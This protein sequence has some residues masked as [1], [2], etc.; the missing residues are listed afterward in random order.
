M[1]KSE[2]T[3]NENRNICLLQDLRENQILLRELERID[4]HVVRAGVL[5]ESGGEAMVGA[6]QI[7]ALARQLSSVYQRSNSWK[8]EYKYSKF[9][10]ET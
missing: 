3:F 5:R 7:I 2:S 10:L 1:Q 6:V 4:T 8:R 9:F